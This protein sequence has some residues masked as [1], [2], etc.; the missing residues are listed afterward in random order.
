MAMSIQQSLDESYKRVNLE[1]EFKSSFLDYSM[2]VIVSRAIPDIR[3][4]LKPVHR[5]ILV[6]MNDLGLHH[7][8]GFR[9]S[10][11]IT[12][13][14]TGKYH[15]HGTA[16]VYQSIARMAQPFSLRYPLVI[17]QGNFGSIDGD[18]PAAERYTEAKM[19]A[20]SDEM[21]KDLKKDT[22]QFVPN[23]DGT[24]TEPTILPSVVPNLLINGSSGIAVGYT[25]EIPPHNLNEIITGLLFFIDNPECTT[26]DLMQYIKGPDFPTGGIINGIEPIREFYE[27]GRGKIK[28][29]GRAVIETDKSDREKIVIT[30]IPYMVN[31][32]RLVENI[33]FL[34]NNKKINGISDLRDES[35]RDGIRIVLD[36]RKHESSNVIINQ[37][38][39]FTQ[40]EVTVGSHMLALVD[41][42]PRLLTLKQ[43][44]SHFL[45]HRRNIVIRRTRF[46]LEKALQRAHILDGLKIA[47]SNIDE[48]IRIIKASQTVKEAEE[49][50][51]SRFELSPLQ[52]KAILDLKLQRLTSLEM[53]KIAKELDDLLKEIKRLQEIL[54]SKVLVDN[55]IK[56][57]L[58][59]LSSRYGDIRRTEIMMLPDD[60]NI[61]DMIK[62]EDIVVF[63]T[64]QM[65]IKRTSLSFYR[66]Q[67]RAGTGKRGVMTKNDDFVD[68]I[69]TAQTLDYFLITTN[70]G[71][72]YWLKAY[73][74]PESGI[75]SMGRAIVNLINIGQDEVI[76]TILPVKEFREDQYLLFATKKGLVKKTALSHFSRPYKSGIIAILLDEDDDLVATKVSSGK[77]DVMLVTRAGM[78]IRFSEE[79]LRATGR[80]TR[81]VIGIKFRSR[82]EVVSLALF[83]PKVAGSAKGSSPLEPYGLFTI[84]NN[85]IG[86]ITFE[87]KFRAQARA[88]IGV[89][90]I[91]LKG[92]NSYVVGSKP[93]CAE[94]DIIVCTQNGKVIR[95]SSGSISKTGRTSQGVKLQS[96]EDDDYVVSFA[97]IT[98][99]EDSE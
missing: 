58:S 1:D 83:K 30:E 55:I 72:L 48:V 27:T 5:R 21:L 71:K 65:Y 63:L 13:E 24:E 59:D 75:T 18:P 97:T 61:E 92:R 80:A 41:M 34:I 66:S 8:S 52:A 50:L 95:F 20:I 98:A 86:K 74:I 81:G 54:K 56:N 47:I 70:K 14:V 36:I 25:T 64:N 53:E 10:A 49:N 87:S 68:R 11:K 29:R 62:Q 82:D 45:S 94:D 38:Y 6:A 90:N 32:S 77:D 78:S 44:L 15:P 35:D 9:K 23:Y 31:K 42:A 76:N 96:L 84:T 99:E 60:P 85:G 12:G 28:L 16:A 51:I 73:E 67:R 46:D 69:F 2:S 4:G 88:G 57:E 3:D 93:V 43:S 39:K 17:G 7:N 37:L 91:R 89:R 22:V 19:S 40:L 79:S 26:Q 33:A